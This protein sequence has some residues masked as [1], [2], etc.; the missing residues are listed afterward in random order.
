MK[1]ILL[2]LS[3][4]L[5]IASIGCAPA[6]QSAAKALDNAGSVVKS[7]ADKLWITPSATPKY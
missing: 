1:H 6:E 7:G 5:V 2:I 4:L 3:L